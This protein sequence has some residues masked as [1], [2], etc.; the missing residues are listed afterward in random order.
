MQSEDARAPMMLYRHKR[1]EWEKSLATAG[2]KKRIDAPEK[3]LPKFPPQVNGTTVN[4]LS[5]M[6]KS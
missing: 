4:K 5:Q 3:M 1:I 6:F 2:K